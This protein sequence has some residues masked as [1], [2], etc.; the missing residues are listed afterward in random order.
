MSHSLQIIFTIINDK[1]NYFKNSTRM[2][3][4]RTNICEKIFMQ[5]NYLSLSYLYTI[6]VQNV[7]YF[8]FLQNYSNVF[9]FFK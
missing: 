1:K 7:I 6:I 4:L 9:F 8:I 5:N 3:L 2:N